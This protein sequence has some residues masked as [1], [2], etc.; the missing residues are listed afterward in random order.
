MLVNNKTLFE[1]KS[2]QKSWLLSMFA[3]SVVP[4]KVKNSR[5]NSPLYQWNDRFAQML[6]AV[7]Y[8]MVEH[9]RNFLDNYVGISR[10]RERGEG[11]EIENTSV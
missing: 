1:K 4:E 2:F 9:A 7:V 6:N 3:T 8:W 5:R 11:R 10:A